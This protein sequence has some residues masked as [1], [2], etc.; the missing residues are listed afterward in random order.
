MRITAALRQHSCTMNLI[1][2]QIKHDC[3]FCGPNT[4]LIIYSSFSIFI[5]QIMYIWNVSDIANIGWP[6]TDRLFVS[7]YFMISIIKTPHWNFSN[8]YG[9]L[10]CVYIENSHNYP[11]HYNIITC[12]V[13]SFLDFFNRNTH[14]RDPISDIR[15]Q[16]MLSLVIPKKKL[17]R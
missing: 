14:K 3:Q 17:N 6:P 8:N 16:L 7:S 12:S 1:L 13:L 10:N 15:R 11:W 9:K 2:K 4:P 5:W